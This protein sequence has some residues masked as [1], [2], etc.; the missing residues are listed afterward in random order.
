M[1]IKRFSALSMQRSIELTFLYTRPL[2]IWWIL[3]PLNYFGCP[4]LMMS[5]DCFV[6]L[7]YFTVWSLGW[8]FAVRMKCFLSAHHSVF[9]REM[10]SP[11]HLSHALLPYPFFSLSSSFL[12]FLKA[13]P[14]VPH[15]REIGSIFFNQN[16]FILYVNPSPATRCHYNSSKS[17]AWLSCSRECQKYS[18]AKNWPQL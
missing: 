8:N 14:R 16:W 15:L 17:H 13:L 6:L 4:V 5:Y 11:P 3:S 1:S 9:L 18:Q 12:Q 10:L 7:I 2:W